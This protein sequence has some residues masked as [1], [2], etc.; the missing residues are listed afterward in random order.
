VYRRREEKCELISIGGIT[1]LG[2]GGAIVIG[3]AIGLAIWAVRTFTR[4]K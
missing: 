1:I 4:P 3:A 2:L